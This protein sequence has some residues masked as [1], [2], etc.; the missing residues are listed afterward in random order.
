MKK[1]IG[2]LT[3]HK[4]INHGAILQAY[5]LQEVLKTYGFNVVVLD[6]NREAK[7]YNYTKIDRIKA[8]FKKLNINKIKIKM[9]QHQFLN[10]KNQKFE[11]FKNKYLCLGKVYN[12]ES[13]NIDIA[14]IGSD[15]VFDFFE[16]YNPFMYGK[17]VKAQKII[18]YAACFGYT[19][20]NSFENYEHRDE[21]VSLISKMDAISYRDDNTGEILNKCCHVSGTKVIDPVLLYGFSLEKEKWN[22]HNWNNKNY[23]LIYSYD[24]N[25]NKSKEVKSIKRFAEENGLKIISVGY[26]HPW[27]D[28]VINADPCEFVEIFNNATYVVTDTFHG[29]IFSLIFGKQFCVTIRNNAFKVLDILKDLN[30]NPQLGIGIYDKLAELKNNPLDY[31]KINLLIEKYRK[32]SIKFLKDNLNN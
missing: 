20:I 16:G 22:V 30:I 13:N 1:N 10:I 7:R 17:D 6:Y 19:T 8:I 26:N 28:E 24:Y 5:A 12:D 15:M 4:T 14:V 27:C 25:M 3:W 31:S 18:S 21:I 2:I 29:T 23:I 32:K 11:T 9:N